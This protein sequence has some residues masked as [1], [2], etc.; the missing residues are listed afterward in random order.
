MQLMWLKVGLFVYTDAAG[1]VLH[2]AGRQLP[3]LMVIYDSAPFAMVALLCV[4][5][6]SGRQEVVTIIARALPGMGDT[7]RMTTTRLTVI[8]TAC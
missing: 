5:D 7:V 3:P 6:D 8:A 1:P 4:R 2:L